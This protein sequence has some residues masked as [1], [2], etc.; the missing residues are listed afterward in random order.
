MVRHVQLRVMESCEHKHTFTVRLT[1]VHSVY[2]RVTYTEH[3][4]DKLQLKFNTFNNV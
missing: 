2:T 1:Y 4:F 3:V